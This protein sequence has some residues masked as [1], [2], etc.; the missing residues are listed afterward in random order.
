MKATVNKWKYFWMSFLP[1]ISLF[2]LMQLIS[3]FVM[4]VVVVYAFR[5]ISISSFDDFYEAYIDLLLNDVSPI[6]LFIYG[7]AALFLT[8]FWYR[9]TLKGTCKIPDSL[10]EGKTSEL[11]TSDGLSLKNYKKINILGLVF[12]AIGFQIV[13]QFF[14]V[15][16]SKLEPTWA[17]EYS[18][19]LE[20]SGLNN[21]SF[22]GLILAY[23]VIGPISEELC[24]RGITFEYARKAMPFW[25]TNILQ[26]LLFGIF[27]GNPL[28]GSMAFLLGL[29]LGYIYGKTRNIKLTIIFHITF[30]VST[31]FISSINITKMNGVLGFFYLFIGLVI[32]Y[33]G[34]VLFMKGV[35]RNINKKTTA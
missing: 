2:F 15:G 31:F 34:I 14:I 3:I 5:V 10:H 19:L 23:V 22:F 32:S 33:L 13:M 29:V 18:D 20:Q 21:D 8:L 16:L 17:K 7:F 24:F 11:L 25:A 35:P 28:Q 30:N 4:E 12:S 9:N 6:T 1:V 26:A 27:H